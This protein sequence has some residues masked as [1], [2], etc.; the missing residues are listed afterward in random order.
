MSL[1]SLPDE[2][3][4]VVVGGGIMGTSTAFFLTRRT[5]RD[6]VLIERDEIASG[7]SGDSSAIVRHHYGPQRIYSELAKWS[8]DFYRSF[9]AETGERIAYAPNPMIR[10]GPTDSDAEDYARA[11]YDVLESLDLPASWY[12]GDELDEQYPMLALDDVDF[13]VSDD[14]SGYS[15]GTD[16]A[17][18][19]ARAAQQQGATVV[20]GV[21]VEDVA[22]EDDAVTAVRT[23][24]GTVETD[25]VVLAAGP[26]TPRIAETVG[27]D[28][29]IVPTREQVVV[30]DPPSTY[31]DEYPD[32]LPSA[33]APGGDWY[34]R[35]DFGDGILVATHH[36]GEEVDPDHYD[37]RPDRETVLELSERLQSF[38]PELDDARVRGQYC[39][40]YSTTPDHD[41]IVDQAGP[42]GC[43]IG[44]GFSGHGFKHAPGVGRMLADLVVDGDTDVVDVEFFSYDRFEDDPAGHGRPDDK[45]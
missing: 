40:V 24:D 32:L 44:C 7:S 34:I 20:T 2:A 11:G 19:F 21:A 4:V 36:T 6:V 28:V 3:D 27:L 14:D 8:H 43:Y 5:E 29:P 30:L 10:L 12:E 26:W 25:D 22:V 37:E 35:P 15:D 13:A 38:V 31:V 45:I 41:F 1:V 17:G 33:G 42:E 9:E 18:G 39:G 16:V 23:T